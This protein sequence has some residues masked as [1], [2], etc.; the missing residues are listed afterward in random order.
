MALKGRIKPGETRNPGGMTLEARAAR[1]AMLKAL[2]EPSRAKRGLAAYDR[3]LEAD[4]P[5]IVKDFMD[6]LAGKVKEHLALEDEDGNALR[7]FVGLT[8]EQIL[9]AIQTAK[10]K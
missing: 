9:V 3:L 4:N 2:A 5:L 1:D 6:R 7:P 10:T 8:F